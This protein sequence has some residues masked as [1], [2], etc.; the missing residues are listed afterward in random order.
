MPQSSLG[1]DGNDPRALKLIELTEAFVGTLHDRVPQSHAERAI[2]SDS[3]LRGEKLRQ[4]P[5]RFIEEHLIRDVADQI[6]GYDYRPQPKGID[7]LEGRI[8][9]F[10]VMNSKRLVLGEI[11]KPNSIEQAREESHDY[12][13]MAS[14]RPAV[15]ISTDGWTWILHKTSEPDGEVTYHSHEPLRPIIRRLGRS[16]RHATKVSRRRLRTEAASFVRRFHID[17]IAETV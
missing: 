15:G 16:E 9:D 8:P 11:K 6:L 10:E 14:R 17:S 1:D 13:E 3:T 2:N 4:L 7:G 12:L 5:E